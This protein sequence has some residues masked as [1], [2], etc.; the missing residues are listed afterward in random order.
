M[1]GR[2]VLPPR[3]ARYRKALCLARCLVFSFVRRSGRSD[4]R[5]P[6]D[7]LIHGFQVGQT[8]SVLSMPVLRMQETSWD[9]SRIMLVN[10][11][12]QDIMTSGRQSGSARSQDDARVSY[13]PRTQAEVTQQYCNMHQVDASN[14]LFLR[15]FR[16]VFENFPSESDT[17]DDGVVVA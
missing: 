15:M 5:F 16:C 13:F 1:S 2:T 11:S 4:A 7:I 12:E 9:E 6:V 14:L 8:L 3:F 17:H 10:G